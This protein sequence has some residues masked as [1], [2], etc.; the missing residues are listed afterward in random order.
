VVA[1]SFYHARDAVELIE[2][3]Y[4]PLKPVSNPLEVLEGNTPLI[5]EEAGTNIAATVDYNY[6]DYDSAAA[7]ADRII[8]AKLTFHR[9]SS[10]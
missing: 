7:K 4:E 3:D 5:H 2:A 9:F 8:R 6:G 10:T 1:D